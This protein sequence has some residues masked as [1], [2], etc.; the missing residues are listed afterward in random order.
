MPNPDTIL[1]KQ[2]RTATRVSSKRGEGEGEGEGKGK[3]EEIADTWISEVV[4]LERSWEFFQAPI[5]QCRRG[6]DLAECAR[7][8]CHEWIKWNLGTK[9]RGQGKEE[10]LWEK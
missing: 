2:R 10:L 1:G 7:E 5:Y 4:I 3:G 9:S 8:R 6:N